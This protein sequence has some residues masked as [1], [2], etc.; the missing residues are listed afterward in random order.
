MYVTATSGGTLYF[1]GRG[2]IYRSQ[3]LD[4]QYQPA[5]ELG[6]EIN[7]LGNPAHPYVAPDES[8]LL[9]DANPPGS[10][11]PSIYVSFRQADDT[12]TEADQLGS[13]ISTDDAELA[14]SVSPDGRFLFFARVVGGNADIYWVDASV[15]DAY[16]P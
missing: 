6:Q 13:G 2:G 10:H 9:F 3:W 14:A 4:G 15:L 11:L 1:T 16:R 7:S 12:W 5:E 8:Y